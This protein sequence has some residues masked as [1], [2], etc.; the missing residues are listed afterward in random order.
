MKARILLLAAAIAFACGEGAPPESETGTPANEPAPV[1]VETRALT[2]GLALWRADGFTLLVPE[3]ADIVRQ[4]PVPPQ[5]WSGILAGPGFIQEVDGETLPG[6][7]AYRLDIATY[8]IPEG[9]TLEGWVAEL[10]ATRNETV[11]T[12]I[13]VPLAGESAL[14]TGTPPGESGPAT[15]WLERNGKVVEIRVTEEPERPLSGIQRHVQ[16]LVLST[17]RWSEASPTP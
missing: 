2:D 10:Q 3:A 7:P 15:Y 16:S 6:P 4:D 14:R 17:F 13:R 5:T 1:P 12:G 11:T 9:E 8:A